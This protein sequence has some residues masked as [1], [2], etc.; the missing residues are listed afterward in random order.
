MTSGVSLAEKSAL[1][2]GAGALGGPALL[3][4]AAAGVGRI[5]LVDAG[6]VE[7]ADLL[8]TAL[9]EEA[10]VGERKASAAARRLARLFPGTMFEPVDR[11]F[12][13][14]AA[15]ELARAADVLVDCSGDLEASFSANDVA[16]T[17]GKPLVHGGVAAF[18]AQLLTV[19][20]RKTG[21][22]R[23]LFESPPAA[24]LVPGAAELGLVG[25]LAGFAGS[26]LGTEAVRILSG[27]RGTY[28]GSL[29]EYESRAAW[30][31]AVPVRLRDGCASC[32]QVEH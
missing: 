14:A 5:S 27:E 1:V 18:T 29:F 32:G 8:A 23:C 9:F 19:L 22:L 21:C 10:D 4:L 11:R 16:V 25:P 12:E 2:L 31:R 20:P 13:G 17:A 7:T 3:A 24:G 30:A 15:L 6:P 28:A 26:L